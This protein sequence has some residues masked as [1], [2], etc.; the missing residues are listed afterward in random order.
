M[1]VKTFW[2]IW[3]HCLTIERDSEESQKY[4]KPEILIDDVKTQQE[5]EEKDRA[6]IAKAA[7]SGQ[8]VYDPDQVDV[9]AVRGG[10]PPLIDDTAPKK[11][12]NTLAPPP[13]PASG[14]LPA[15]GTPTA[16][17]GEASS[18]TTSSVPA[19]F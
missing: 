4:Q 12:G 7:S 18:S 1:R 6:E 14:T 10:T 2:T 15:A 19:L 13:P 9:E 16:A 3:N 5:A 17:S 8:V 11:T